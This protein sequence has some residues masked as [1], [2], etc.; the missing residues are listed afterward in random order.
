MPPQDVKYWH[1]FESFVA[2]IYRKLGAKVVK[3]NYSIAGSQIDIYVEEETK[4]GQLIKV[5]VECK[6]YR[7]KVGVSVIRQFAVT[8]KFLKDSGKIDKNVLVAYNGFTAEAFQAAECAEI[9]LLSFAELEQKLVDFSNNDVLI[10]IDKEIENIQQPEIFEKTVF[11]MMPFDNAMNDLYIYGIRGCAEKLGLKCIRADEI[12][13]N[14]NIINEIKDRIKKSEFLIGEM[15]NT[16]KNVY[17][18][19]GYAHGLGKEV[20]L[21]TNNVE[22]IPFD[23]KLENHIVYKSIREL[24]ENL[25]RRIKTMMQDMHNC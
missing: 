3:E 10:E 15:T 25:E 6:Y 23:L 11:V 4:S 17:Y 9:D 2:S 8:A 1:Q 5:N 21:L 12:E 7:H 19:V 16:N 13:H 14:S 24:E 20:I 22:E 18:E